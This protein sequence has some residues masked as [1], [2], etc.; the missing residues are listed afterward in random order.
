MLDNTNPTPEG[1]GNA[2]DGNDST[3]PDWRGVEGV[4][5]TC[6]VCGQGVDDDKCAACAEVAWVDARMAA[7]TPL[8][9]VVPQPVVP[10]G[11]DLPLFR[12]KA[13]ALVGAGE[14]C[15]SLIVGNITLA[16]ASRGGRVLVLDG[17]MD[18]ASWKQRFEELG[19][20]YRP[21]V[22]RN[23]FHLPITAETLRDARRIAHRFDVA[24][25]DSATP[26]LIALGVTNEID[27]VQVTRALDHTK[28]LA[29]EGPAVAIIDHIASKSET[30]IPRGATAKFNTLDV[31][32]GARLDGGS[33]GREG[34]WNVRVTVEKDRFALVG[35]RRDTLVTF[36]PEE[37]RLLGVRWRETQDQSHRLTTTP[38]DSVVASIAA[39]DPPAR[40]ANDAFARLGG[41]RG[42]VLAAFKVWRE[43]R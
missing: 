41:T 35:H 24:A 8:S 12:G 26:Y 15:K 10:L 23:I 19:A 33:P 21:D 40:S 34:P 18:D 11:T 22:L 32:Y 6:G 4:Q 28:R 42:T 3:G 25:I 9:D 16:V 2:R 13:H 30:T 31:C 37:A 7:L 38:L 29:A 17:E 43:A 39:L 14:S 27:N 20:V 5:E 1:A 36:T